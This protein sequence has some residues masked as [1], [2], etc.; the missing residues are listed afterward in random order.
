METFK[1][2]F[3]VFSIVLLGYVIVR[4]K[5]LNTRDINGVSRLVF[6]ILI[7]IL[8]FNSLSKLELPAQFKWQFFLAYYLVVLVVYGLAMWTSKQF[9]AYSHEEQGVFGM[10]ST[11]SNLVFVGLPIISAGFGEEA[12]LPLFMI[13]S[14]HSALQF[15]LVTVI[16]EGE[17]GG[18]RSA[19]QLT[20]DT[21]KRLA[22]N[23]IIIGLAL[24]LLVNI[25][26]VPVP[27]VL[28]ET[29]S[30]IGR[31]TL[32]CALLV[33]GGSL[34]DYK[35][36]GHFAEAGTMIG[37]KMVLM[38]ALVWIL[39]FVVFHIDPL[40]GAVAVMAAGM[41][42]GVNAYMVAQKYQMG[43]ATISTALLVSTLLAALSQSI[44][45]AIFL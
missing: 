12:L 21:I 19:A 25:L 43:I 10:G 1:I 34:N 13:I 5:V 20:F 8:L 3:P 7:P 6:N 40:W 38:P 37:L 35:V 2:L 31:A 18:S 29:L 30:L 14:I 11:Y 22:R 15:F 4:L 42:V 39:A 28:D 16:V 36:A 33:L 32:P 26:H 24:G 27:S 41:P 45:L 9:F 23:P 44:L 17:T